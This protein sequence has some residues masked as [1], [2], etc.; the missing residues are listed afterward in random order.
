MNA[1]AKQA[2][3]AREHVTVVP[4][5]QLIIVDGEVLFFSFDAP[6]HLH[7]LQWHQGKGHMEWNNDWNH[8]LFPS[9]YEADVNPFVQAWEQ[10]KERLASLSADI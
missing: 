2:L 5:D 1:A 8:P 6:E 10:E 4:G 3:K 7:A 9:D